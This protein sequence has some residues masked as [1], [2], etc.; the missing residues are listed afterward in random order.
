L[1]EN[2]DDQGARDAHAEHQQAGIADIHRLA[3]GRA[4]NQV[5]EIRTQRESGERSDEHGSRHELPV[6]A[7]LG[8]FEQAHQQ[9]RAQQ[10]QGLI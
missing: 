4:C 8:N 6:A 9:Q 3:V 2:H 1:L 10:R 7:V 5:V